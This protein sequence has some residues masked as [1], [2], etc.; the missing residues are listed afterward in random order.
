MAL[1][2]AY[3][4]SDEYLA[5]LGWPA[6]AARADVI[7]DALVA[8]SRIIDRGTGNRQF[9]SLMPPRPAHSLWCEP[10][11]ASS[12]TTSRQLLRRSR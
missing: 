6:N 4:T 12:L 8:A 1:S 11:A 2:D 7:N 3:A 9:D 5:T 10:P